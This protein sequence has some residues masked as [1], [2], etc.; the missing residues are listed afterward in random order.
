[1]V[2][3]AIGSAIHHFSLF[4]SRPAAT[5]RPERWLEA[6]QAV[7]EVN[8]VHST[9]LY[10]TRDMYRYMHRTDPDYPDRSLFLVTAVNPCSETGC[11]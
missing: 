7:N 3:V 4:H 6:D 10:S 8:R 1:M 9:A 11:D 2:R 5:G